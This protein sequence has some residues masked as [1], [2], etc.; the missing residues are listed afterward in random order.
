V[1]RTLNATV[2]AVRREAF[3]DAAERLIRTKG[4]EQMSIQDVQDEL[5][6]SRGAFYHYFHSKERLLE[7]VVDRVADG[8]IAALAPIVTDPGVRAEAKLAHFVLTSGRWKSERHDLLLGLLEVWQSD[9]NAVVR[10][11]LWRMAR[12]RVGPLVADIVRQGAAEGTFTVGSP[13]HS[14]RVL[15]TVIEASG[16]TAGDL[17]LLRRT[18]EVPAEEIR[19][20]MAAYEEAI[21]RILGLPA[22]SFRLMDDETFHVWFD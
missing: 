22:G 13:E 10:E 17:L 9:S 15:L 21:E 19:Q 3:L 20:A 16:E 1:V 4:Y 6:V 2:H 5:D 8:V 11:K 18:N 12:A 7:A 14:A